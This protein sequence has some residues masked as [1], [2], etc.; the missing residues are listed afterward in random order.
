M[1]KVF[2]IIFAFAAIVLCACETP[3]NGENNN[4]TEQ[5][6]P[7]PENALS[8]L[9]D[10]KEVVFDVAQAWVDCFGDYYKTGHCMWGIFLQAYDVREQVYV[11]LLTPIADANTAELAVPTGEFIVTTPDRW[12]AGYILPGIMTEEYDEL[13][14]EYSWY[15]KMDPSSTVL[16]V[17]IEQAPIVEGTLTI[18]EEREGYY[19]F[20]FEFKD[21][22]YNRIYGTYKGG[23]VIE[24]Y[25]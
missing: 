24:D 10:D 16:P 2:A 19:D 12:D 13:Y 14:Q 6:P 5:E 9:Y 20:S 15:V 7:R 22:A 3:N 23:A 1:R 25:R 8:T 17:Y 18:T 21:D 4:G 11:E